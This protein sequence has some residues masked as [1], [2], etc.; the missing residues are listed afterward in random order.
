MYIV[1]M[2]VKTYLQ[3]HLK[4]R[5]VYFGSQFEGIGKARQPVMWYPQPGS[6][7]VSTLLAFSLPFSAGTPVHGV[8]VFTLQ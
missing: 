2:V 8:V 1:L 6:G 5:R 4:D 7:E 3:K